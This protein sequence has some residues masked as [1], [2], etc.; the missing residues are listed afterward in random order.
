MFVIGTAGHVDHG[1]STLVEALTGIDPD[2]L[3]EEK[4]RGMT[5]DL[6]FAWLKL[7]GGAEV[8]IVDVPGHERF[9]KNMLAGVGGIDLALLVIAADEG[10]M[11]QTREHLA[12][13]D[14]LGVERGVI[15][16][17]KSDL[18]DR[19]WLDMVAADAEEVVKETTLAGSPV[20]ACS[21]TTGEGLDRLLAVIEER[22][23]ATTPKRDLGRPRLPIDRVFTIAGFGTVVTGTLIDGSLA[24]GQE[25]E[26]VPALGGGHVTTLRSRVRG[27]QTHRSKVEV[28]Q[29][30]TRTAVN[31]A[32]IETGDI[33]R[34]Q[35]LTTPGWLQPSIAVD[36][37]LRAL[38]SLGHPL[39]H[40][41]NVSFHCLASETP[42]KL[43]L[44]DRDEMAPGDEA[45]AQVRL[46]W[47]AALL[48]GD[49]FVLRDA[50]D[51]IGGGIIV[52][53]QARRH[54]RGRASVLEKLAQQQRGE[55]ADVLYAA[56][57]ALEPVDRGTALARTDLSGEA[58]ASAFAALV[59]HGRII[60][61]ASEGGLAFTR[62]TFEALT[63]RAA[64]ALSAYHGGHPL[65]PGLPKEELRS[66]LDLGQ[67]VFAPLLARWLA[68]GTLVEAGRALSLPGWQP[69]LTAAQ[70]SAAEHYI[71]TLRSAPY[72]PPTTSRP[73]DDLVAYL[74]A[75]GEVVEVND[76]IV[77]ARAAYDELVEAVIELL[78]ERGTI[79]VADVR[80]RFGT[81]RRYVLA[82]LE[83]LDSLRV[84][85]RRGDDR[86]LGPGTHQ[87]ARKDPWS[88]TG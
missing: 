15:V 5:I 62:A 65:R 74:E 31:L 8:S 28:A 7:P 12:I 52:E 35:V 42:A 16:I 69:H 3:R 51:T 9:I 36:V 19:D 23:Q 32:G 43:R 71:A 29:P 59:V 49:R 30:G 1:K 39:R 53:T 26:V 48:R 34:G 78:R 73:D 20:V 87:P 81:S 67:R 84:T 58:G 55:P 64:E 79:T 17:T 47:P 24:L 68:E 61:L 60:P 33:W 38:A 14:L 50:N 82:L 46:S 88:A 13:L 80:D 21:A 4:Q 27:L 37:R 6:G 57:A 56:I 25:V 72:S 63:R 76:S 40:N 41:L 44:L 11:P 18:V 70:S 54:P 10:V 2:R 86:V 45:W 85:L 22:L 75:Q 83:H 66:R 77:F